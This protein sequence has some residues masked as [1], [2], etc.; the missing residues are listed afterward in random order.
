[1]NKKAKKLTL[2][3]DTLQALEN[4]DLLA[5]LGGAKPGPDQSWYCPSVD[6]GCPTGTCQ[7]LGV[8]ICLC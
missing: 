7:S 1:M 2:N 6:D 8:T 3:R 5:A 4:P